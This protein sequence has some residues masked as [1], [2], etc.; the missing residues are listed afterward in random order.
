MLRYP[1][2]KSKAKILLVTVQP[3]AHTLARLPSLLRKADVEVH[4]LAPDGLVHRSRYVRSLPVRP[5]DLPETLHCLREHLGVYQD[6]YRLILLG[7]DTLVSALCQE[8][9]RSWLAPWFP[10]DPYWPELPALH[11][12]DQFNALCHRHGFSAP[13]NMVC[14]NLAAAESAAEELG[15]PVILKRHLGY[16]GN[17]VRQ[18][19]DVTELRF[20]FKE[21]STPPSPD[22]S[23]QSFL[24]GRVGNS[25]VVSRRGQ[26]LQR[27]SYY[28][29]KTWPGSLGPSSQTTT[30]QNPVL[31]DFCRRLSEI[32]G[33]HGAFGFDWIESS[34]DGRFYLLEFNPRITP[35][36]CH[37]KLFGLDLAPDIH[38]LWSEPFTGQVPR[39][40]T[41]NGSQRLFPQDILR[42]IDDG[43]GPGLWGNVWDI[44]LLR[45]YV[46]WSDPALGIACFRQIVRHAVRSQPRLLHLL[47]SVRNRLSRS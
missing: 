15:Y 20:Y 4:L 35:A 40:I 24:A 29:R 11:R 22:L 30:T 43:D 41:R 5:R 44:V 19:K 45:S 36:V 42:C 9:D 47:K 25:Y 6:T 13:R 23:I 8:N 10:V 12:K 21:L 33:F 39:T 18:A 31:D 3:E 26:V 32:T 37:G 17:G 34:L 46:P 38:L 2:V 16:G 27:Y 1:S 28:Y 7:D 14:S